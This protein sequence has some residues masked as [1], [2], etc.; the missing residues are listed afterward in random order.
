MPPPVT[1]GPRPVLLVGAGGQLGHALAGAFAG[2]ALVRGVRT[3]PG[4]RDVVV[5]FEDLAGVRDTL[6]RLR[7]GLVLV[8]GAMCHV[9]G[10]ET[11]PARCRSINTDGPAVVADYA[12]RHGA[13]VVLFSTDHVF[14]GRQSSYVETDAVAP[15]N[16]YAAS[17]AAAEEAVRSA[18]A[19][20]HLILRT[21]WVYGSDPRR[22]NFALRLVDRLRAGEAVDVP[23]DQWG[24]PTFTEDLATATRT[25]VD[26][27]VVGTFHATGPDFVNRADL[28][29]RICD[30]A[31]VPAD[32]LRPVPTA[33]L[34]QAAP[35]PLRVRLDCAALRAR[36]TTPF[37]GVDAGLR[38]FVTS[39][40][41][42]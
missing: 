15:L 38:A 3:Q 19:D 30:A 21:A 2:D 27:G 41:R 22:R 4:P 25:L 8:A 16:V 28:A 17:K 18:V 5:D 42:T 26:D 20:R 7:P 35:R 29:R 31:G 13:T 10:C 36:I 40:K 39:E 11:D 24:S 14:D 32:R 6:G 33:V 34:G 1:G 37:R 12:R 9:D 23:E